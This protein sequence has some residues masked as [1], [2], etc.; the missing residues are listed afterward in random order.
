VSEHT[1]ERLLETAMAALMSKQ[2]ELQRLY[3][4]GDMERW[5]LDQESATLKFFDAHDRLAVE[6]QILNIGSFSP[7]HSSWKWAWSNPT[8]PQALREQALPLKELQA[9]TGYELF[10]ND[11]AVALEDESMAWELTAIAVQHLGALGCYR[12]PSPPD[13]P[14]VFLAITSLRHASH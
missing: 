14:T 10:G 1:F 13:G 3:T 6:A 5:W 12:A 4:L 7:K 9:I 8:V 2:E 11:E